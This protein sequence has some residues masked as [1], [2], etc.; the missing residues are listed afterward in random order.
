MTRICSNPGK[1]AVLSVMFLAASGGLAL[2]QQGT[3]S[4]SEPTTTGLK[5]GHVD[6]KK[7]M[8][9][10]LEAAQKLRESIQ[11]LARQK[12]G[13][14]RDAAIQAAKDA[15]LSTQRAMLQLPPELRVSN[16]SVREAREWPTAM[17]RLD[18][19]SQRLRESVEAMSKEQA[20][21]RRND[22]I[23]S[24]H[25]ALSQAQEAMLAIPEDK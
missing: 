3:K 25:E 24:V 10:L 6:Y 18:A 21:K 16:V 23:A 12:A 2:A 7:E 5:V 9:S 4:G 8:G 22:A 15:L 14:E 11:H 17:A 20:G 13:P 19:A 1:T